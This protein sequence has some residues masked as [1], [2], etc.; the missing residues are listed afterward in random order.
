MMNKMSL[1][2]SS[3][4]KLALILENALCM[5]GFASDREWLVSWGEVERN[6]SVG[7]GEWIE[8]IEEVEEV[9]DC[10]RGED[11]QDSLDL[12]FKITDFGNQYSLLQLVA[13]LLYCPESFCTVRFGSSD[14]HLQGEAPSN[15][16]QR[17]P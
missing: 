5:E 16:L 11:G 2:S 14:R 6:G 9:M 12:S 10:A 7:R 17:E 4:N 8:W 13:A 15:Y 1:I 3:S